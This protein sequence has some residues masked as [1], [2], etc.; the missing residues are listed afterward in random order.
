MLVMTIMV[1]T[2][3]IFLQ[4]YMSILQQ[5]SHIH[6]DDHRTEGSVRTTIFAHNTA[7]MVGNYHPVV[8]RDTARYTRHYYGRARFGSPFSSL[9]KLS[10]SMDTVF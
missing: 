4:E 8:N 2:M 5:H 10:F 1:M 9:Q 7:V 3:M 6:N